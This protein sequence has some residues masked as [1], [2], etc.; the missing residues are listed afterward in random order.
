MRRLVSKASLPWRERLFILATQVAIIAIMWREITSTGTIIAIG[1]YNLGAY[2]FIL[3]AS[4][5]ALAANATALM[6]VVGPYLLCAGTLLIIVMV[7][8]VRGTLIDPFASLTAV[9]L[10]GPLVVFLILAPLVSQFPRGVRIIRTTIVSAAVILALLC[11]F[12]RTTGLLLTTHNIGDGRPMLSWGG[13]LIAIGCIF[14]LSDFLR[15]RLRWLTIG[16]LLLCY[17]GLLATGQGTANLCGFVGCGLVITLEPGPTRPFRIMYAI[18]FIA[19]LATAWLLAP[20]LFSLST[21]AEGSSSNL[22]SYLADRNRTYET[23]HYIWQGLWNSYAHWSQL[24]QLIGLPSGEKPVVWIPLWN[25]T[26]WQFSMH[27][28]YLQALVNVGML[29]LIFF[30]T[31]FVVLLPVSLLRAIATS[32]LTGAAI[33]PAAGAAIL[34]MVALFGYSYDL[35]GELSPLLMLGFGGTLSHRRRVLRRPKPL[36]RTLLTVPTH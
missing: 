6:E 32:R 20:N 21:L 14:L 7:N 36:V 12:R 19:M 16:L 17:V 18:A 34:L 28:T 29:G 33:S 13:L 8:V 22:A 15:F 4:L 11:I 27:S 31:L 9:R 25:G 26:Y 3:A 2:E 24:D 30:G 35:G 5:L 10:T 1:N 23:R